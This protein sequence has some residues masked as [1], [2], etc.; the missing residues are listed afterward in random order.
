MSLSV[1]AK[2]GIN[3]FIEAVVKKYISRAASKPIAN[4]G[5]PFVMAKPK[6]ALLL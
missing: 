5:N 2:K 6:S 3:T 1:K 4:S